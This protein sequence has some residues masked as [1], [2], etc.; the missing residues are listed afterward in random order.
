MDAIDATTPQ[1][2]AAAA[3]GNNNKNNPPPMRKINFLDSSPKTNTNDSSTHALVL[4]QESNNK[5][6]SNINIGQVG[7]VDNNND[8]YSSQS[9]SAS[10]NLE[11]IALS[12]W[13][14]CFFQTRH[15]CFATQI[16]S[17]AT[18]TTSQD[19]CLYLTIHSTAN[20]LPIFNTD[21]RWKPPLIDFPIPLKYFYA[22]K[23]PG[24]RSGTALFPKNDSRR[25]RK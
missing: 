3:E 14:R 2:T 6:N 22:V 10:F 23:V 5:N 11:A 13:A 1:D 16:T 21:D 9:S 8:N 15:H 19:T 4:Q 20:E 12:G 17:G 24:S 18:S 25:L 7:L